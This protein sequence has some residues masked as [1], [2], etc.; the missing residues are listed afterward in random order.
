M[1][2]QSDESPAIMQLLSAQKLFSSVFRADGVSSDHL[3]R[4]ETYNAGSRL[5]ADVASQSP[6]MVDLSYFL[7]ESDVTIPTL[8]G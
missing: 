8:N 5:D 1:M 7:H 4:C 6:E 3:Q 2:T